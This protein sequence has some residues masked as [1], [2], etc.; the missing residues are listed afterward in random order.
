MKRRDFLK[1]A[2]ALPA[3]AA[4]PSLAA[5]PFA[6]TE[7]QGPIYVWLDGYFFVQ[8]STGLIYSDSINWTDLWLKPEG[9][10]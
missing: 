6:V 1:A 2:L 4:V 10:R 8:T 7:V 3:V 5:S 9:T